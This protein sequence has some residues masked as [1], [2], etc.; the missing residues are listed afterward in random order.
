[1]P[2][3]P[4]PPFMKMLSIGAAVGGH[5]TPPE[6]YLAEDVDFVLRGGG[7]IPGTP[8]EIELT[9]SWSEGLTRT[10]GYGSNV[11]YNHVDLLGKVVDTPAVDL[12]VGGGLGWRS[13]RLSEEPVGVTT[14][15][16]ALGFRSNPAL[17][18]VMLASVGVRARVW[19]PVSARLDLQG[20]VSSGEEPATAPLHLWPVGLATLG[21]DVRWQPPPDRDR[22]GVADSA[23]KCPDSQEDFDYF[24]DKDGCLDP[25]DDKDHILDVADQCKSQAEDLDG[26][27]DDDGCLDHNDDGDAFPDVDDTCTLEPETENAWADGDG[28]PDVVPADLQAVLGKQPQ[29]GFTPD[30]ALLPAAEP[31]LAEVA[32]ALVAHPEVV[33]QVRVAT[34]SSTDSATAYART[35]AQARSLHARLLALGVP[36]SQLVMVSSGDSGANPTAATEEARALDRFVELALVDTL[37]SDGKPIQFTPLPPERW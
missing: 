7:Q 23:D 29:V 13:V 37:G 36:A 30:G 3:L 35:L 1:M 4:I 22:D 14:P 15:Q 12:T 26:Y 31:R 5:L 28:C 25:D 17:D 21:V 11:A 2:A 6:D 20:G 27:R 10:G 24:E 34:D 32:A 18:F 8:A 16:Q 33:L 9:L 19:G